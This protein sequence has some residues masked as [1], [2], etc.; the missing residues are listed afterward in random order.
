MAQESGGR[1]VRRKPRDSVCALGRG[2]SSLTLTHDNELLPI[3]WSVTVFPNF[4]QDLHISLVSFLTFFFSLHYNSRIKTDLTC[5]TQ[6]FL[7]NQK[8]KKFQRTESSGIRF[9]WKNASNVARHENQMCHK[10]DGN[11]LTHCL[12]QLND[13]FL[14]CFFFFKEKIPL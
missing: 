2:Q 12:F 10:H 3:D 4:L 11:H 9:P 14:S 5:K 1:G 13:V 8:C 6:A 7:L